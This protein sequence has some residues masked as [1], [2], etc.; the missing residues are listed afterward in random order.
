MKS[1]K[2]KT[3]KIRSKTKDVIPHNKYDYL[4]EYYIY[5]DGTICDIFR[6]VCRDL[7]TSSAAEIEMD[8]LSL[9]NFF[10][11]YEEDIKIISINIPTSCKNQL[12][13]IQHKI[14]ICKNEFHKQQLLKKQKECIWIEKNRMDKEFYIMIFASTKEK[15]QSNKELLLSTLEVSKMV[16]LINKSQKDEVLMKMANKNVKR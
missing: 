9:S 11:K 13:Y 6:I 3:I 7:A 15:Y 10:A 5:D 12:E 14:D 4:N 1:S 16:S 2:K 8:M